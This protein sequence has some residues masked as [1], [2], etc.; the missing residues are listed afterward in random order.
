MTFFPLFYKA[1]PRKI[2]WLA[3]GYAASGKGTTRTKVFWF[4]G[5]STNHSALLFSFDLVLLSSAWNRKQQM[6]LLV[7]QV[8]KS[9]T[10]LEQTQE[11]SPNPLFMSVATARDNRMTWPPART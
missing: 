4:S 5:F 6:F 3:W 1:V 7:K 2:K 11:P 10:T 9:R 8:S